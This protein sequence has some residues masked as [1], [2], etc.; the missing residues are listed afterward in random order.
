LFTTIED[1]VAQYVVVRTLDERRIIVPLSRFISSS[2]ENWS[3]KSTQKIGTV[4]LYVDYKA[5]I[6]A[7][8]EHLRQVAS[9]C[10]FWD[11]RVCEMDV[12]DCTVSTITLLC[13]L[14]ATTPKRLDSLC[15]YVR[16][17]M[18]RFIASQ[19]STSPVRANIGLTGITDQALLDLANRLT[20][21]PST[22]Q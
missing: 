4:R 17:H 15:A 7:L 18:I 19:T 8:R 10:E 13:R 16:E 20:T 14:S 12:S 11:G 1:L 6:D 21:Q 22:S 3:R 2:F 5:S 9:K